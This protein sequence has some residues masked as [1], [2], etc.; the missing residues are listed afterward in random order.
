MDYTN[1]A[2]FRPGES[3]YVMAP[4]YLWNT[5]GAYQIGVDE[6]GDV[7]Q[8]SLDH[9]YVHLNRPGHPDI[10]D[11]HATSDRL[12]LEQ[13][14]RAPA[15]S[16]APTAATLYRRR[17]GPGRI[18]RTWFSVAALPIHRW[19][20]VPVE[21]SLILAQG[22]R[23]S[24]GVLGLSIAVSGGFLY[25]ICGYFA[26]SHAYVRGIWTFAASGNGTV[27]ALNFAKAD[28]ATPATSP[29]ARSRAKRC[30]AFAREDDAVTGVAVEELEPLGQPGVEAA[31]D[32]LG[33]L[34]GDVLTILQPREFGPR[35]RGPNRFLTL[36]AVVAVRHY[37]RTASASL[38]SCGI[39]DGRSATGTPAAP[40]A[41][42]LLCGVPAVPLMIAPA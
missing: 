31:L 39:S 23:G 3:G 27:N 7:Y 5:D 37:V 35:R 33:D 17:K 4:H 15:C 25:E 30:S 11:G 20:Q 8:P 13:R 10:T 32:V 19:G 2:V 24:G 38:T 29:S 16:R 6:R 1:V 26:R 40:N 9:L 14:S 18:S 22:C 41:A 28:I 12:A 42:T 21:R 34:A 36:L